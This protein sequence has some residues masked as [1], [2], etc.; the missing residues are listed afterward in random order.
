V[1]SQHLGLYEVGV[2]DSQKDFAWIMQ[3]L[4]DVEVEEAALQAGEEISANGYVS[5]PS[6]DSSVNRCDFFCDMVIGCIHTQVG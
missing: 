6:Q 4:S 1:E 3:G 2:V 5:K